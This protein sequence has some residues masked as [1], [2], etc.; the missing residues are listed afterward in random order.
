MQTTS[1]LCNHKEVSSETQYT[2]FQTISKS[3]SKQP[4]MPTCIWS[5]IVSNYFQELHT[6]DII[7]LHN[8]NY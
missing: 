1:D 4:P 8:W 7:G 5:L 2:S 3:D 6:S